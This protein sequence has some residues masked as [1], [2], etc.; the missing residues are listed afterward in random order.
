MIIFIRD[1]L[2]R[3]TE[4]GAPELGRRLEIVCLAINNYSSETA[5]MHG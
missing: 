3:I 2:A 4:S 1:M 5:T